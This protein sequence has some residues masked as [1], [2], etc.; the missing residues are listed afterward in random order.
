[1]TIRGGGG[2]GCMALGD[3]LIICIESNTF[4]GIADRYKCTLFA[5]H[6]PNYYVSKHLLLCHENKFAISYIRINSRVVRQS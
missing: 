6:Q 4:F 5:E 1:M 2:E 3:S